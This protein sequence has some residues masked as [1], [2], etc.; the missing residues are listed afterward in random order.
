MKGPSLC[1]EYG[2]RDHLGNTRLEFS[3]IKTPA[4]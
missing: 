3:R 1:D 4:S 2:I